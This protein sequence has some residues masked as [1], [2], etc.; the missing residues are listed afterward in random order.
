M[1]KLISTH[2]H[3]NV[4]RR[5]SFRKRVWLLIVSLVTIQ[6]I[7]I[8]T[9]FHYTLDKSIK[10]QIS[11]KALI[12]AREIAHNHTLIKGILTHDLHKIQKT[13]KELQLVSDADFIVI[14]DKHG[15]RLA[16]P[17][18]D[19]IGLPMKGGDNKRALSLGEHYYSIRKGTLGMAIRG[20]SPIYD[21]DGNIIGIVS[22][23]YL[24]VGIRDWITIYTYPVFF[25]MFVILLISSLGAWVFTRH[26]KQK[27]YNME[28]EEI[29][30]SFKLQRSILQSVYEGILAVD[31]HGTILSVNARAL[32]SL[33]V[34][35]TPEHLI[36]RS[37]TEFVTPY[38]FF[39]GNNARGD[40]DPDNRQDELITCNGETLIA[41]RISI[42]D[43]DQ[44][45]GWV[46]SFR[47]R[48]DINTLTTQISQIK[49]HTENLR[50]LRH[51]QANQ[52]SMISG[53][54]Q[55]GAYDDA[56]NVIKTETQSQQ[57]LIDFISQTF[58]SRIVAGLLIGKY[59][60]AKELGIQLEFDP[61][62]QLQHDPYCM[63]ADELS[64]ILGNLLD[65]AF[66][67]TLKNPQS[68]K[69]ITLLLSDAS[70]ELV[71]EV[72]DNGVGIPEEISD[73][74]F[75]KGVTSKG[76]PGHGIGLYLVHHFVTRA[77]G[78]ILLDSA[79]P[80]GTI[81]SIFIPNVST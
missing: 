52:L 7:L 70:D 46:V 47:K 37:V 74:L 9:F 56:V 63:T 80:S 66:E 73:S 20:K 45:I 53:M 21:P 30:L 15:I 25:T 51:E 1:F 18:T 41:N 60:R 40:Y 49:Q 58:Y 34:A 29:A 14:G 10:H 81:F 8:A 54:I 77:N 33:G 59:S 55:I 64:A 43:Q 17:T 72:A 12:Q 79:E 68:N 11:T 4:C 13:V 42:W 36:G 78:E 75:T 16:H 27:M 61:L 35:H 44:Q 5:V 76:Q 50:V 31:N 69:T 6:L 48:D 22:I 57:Q 3:T 71:I 24:L 2:L 23:G 32:T 38:A 28:P 39:M 67:A 26:I 19:I 65:N 62:C